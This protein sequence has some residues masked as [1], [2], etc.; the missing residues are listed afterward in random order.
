MSD[1]RDSASGVILAFLLGG[2]AGAALA[3]LY[4]PRSGRE[5]RDLLGDKIREGKERGRQVKEKLAQRGKEM[6]DEAAGYIE[7][8]KE[9]LAD[10]K[11]R[12]SAAVDAGKAAYREE[13][14]KA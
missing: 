11:E 5:T 1:D 10:R 13:K 2:L 3:V 8:Q 4:A 14:E 9:E 6:M 12:L 7:R